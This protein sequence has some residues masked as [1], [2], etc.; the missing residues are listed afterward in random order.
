[1]ERPGTTSFRATLLLSALAFAAGIALLIYSRGLPVYIVSFDTATEA[2]M[3]WCASEP[4]I[5]VDS[6]AGAAYNAL[7]GSRYFY[8]DA[9]IALLSGGLA[10][11]GWAAVLR[12]RTDSSNGETWLRTPHRKSTYFLLGLSVLGWW[13]IS[14]IVSLSTD[15]SRRRFPWCADSLVTFGF[16]R[17][18]VPLLFW[19][20]ARP[21]R[22]WAIT[23][24]S[25]PFFVLLVAALIYQAR[26]SG[27]L[28]TPAGLLALYLVAAT[29][30]ALVA[31]GR[32]AE[33]KHSH[34]AT[35]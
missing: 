15:L 1:M 11:A 33:A 25:I 14:M 29:R 6:E 23:L 26:S 19:D 35:A 9:A 18:P 8:T 28:Q 32:K 22:T 2:F 5:H 21:I 20:H 7:F 12:Y 34:A 31:P 30:A 24:A 13:W 16:G 27:S 4:R 3:R 17:L 10:L